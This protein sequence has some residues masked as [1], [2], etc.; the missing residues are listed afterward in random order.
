MNTVLKALVSVLLVVV[1]TA[2]AP[3]ALQKQTTAVHMGL[4]DFTPKKPKQES[5]G[6]ID[7]SVFGGRGQRVTIRED[8]DNAMW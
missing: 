5:A 3:V 6:G 2:F 8:E 4:F 1:S 7:K